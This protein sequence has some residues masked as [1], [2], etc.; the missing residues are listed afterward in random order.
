MK[1]IVLL[2]LAAIAIPASAASIDWTLNTAAAANYMVGSDGNKLNGTA[3]LLLTSDANSLGTFAAA[4]KFLTAM[5]DVALGS[6]TI[7]DGINKTKQTATSDKL[8]APTSYSFSVLVFDG[9]SYYVASAAKS[10]TAYNLTGD[11][12]TDAKAITFT[13]NEMYASA[14]KRGTQAYV[15][16]PEPA[17][18]ALALLGLGLMIK[19]RKA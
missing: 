6:A 4:D 11:V 3:Y 5:E 19:R 17:T 1:K 14:A 7:T 16:V 9:S 15:A 8:V 12:Y 18:A 2:A 10:M 13:A